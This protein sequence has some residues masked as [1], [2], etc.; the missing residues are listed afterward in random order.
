MSAPT[1][2]SSAP[3]LDRLPEAK[4]VDDVLRNIDQIIHWATKVESHIGYFAVVYQRVTLVIR[5]AING[6]RYFDD[7]KRVTQLDVAFAQRY[8]NALN[9][10]FYPD[11]FGGLTLP[12]E[13]VFVGAQDRHAIILQHLMSAFNAHIT[14]DLGMAC[15][16]VAPGGMKALEGDFNR[17]N[18][19]L[20]DQIPGVVQ[21]LQQLSPELRWTRR[22]IPNELGV[23]NRMLKKLRKGAWAFAFYM[24]QFP[25]QASRRRVHQ[26]AWT[27]TLGAWYLQPPARLTPFPALV[28][29]VAKHESPNVP[30]N[31]RALQEMKAAPAKPAKARRNG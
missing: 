5:A 21:V 30:D 31:I 20:C 3:P 17:V 23:F 28:G 16:T 10:Y 18:D 26:A 2:S 24:D 7:E 9:A 22:L 14:F 29:A 27:A 15:L 1:T 11:E 4:T 12:W 13:V 25:D 8:F 19:L 6:G